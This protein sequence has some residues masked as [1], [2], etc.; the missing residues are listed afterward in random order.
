MQQAS[1][2]DVAMIGLVG[3]ACAWAVAGLF[4]WLWYNRS[5][6]M[7]LLRDVPTVP[8]KGIFVGLTETRGVVEHDEPLEAGLTGRKCVW[9]EWSVRE[10]WRRTQRYKDQKG[11]WRTRI[12]TGSDVVASGGQWTDLR[13]RDDTGAIIVRAKGADWTPTSTF[14]R[15]VG[16]R[17]PLYRTKAPGVTVNGSTGQRTF[18]ES[19]VPIGA[20][21]W[22]MG[23]AHVRADGNA[24][25]IGDGAEEGVFMIS[26]AGE[27]SHAG[28]AHFWAGFGLVAAGFAA[29]AGGAALAPVAAL[30]APGLPR[31]LP[32]LIGAVVGAVV[33]GAAAGLLWGL[34]IRN[35][36]V[37][38]RTRWERSASLVDVELK[39]RSDLIPN[40]AAVAQAGAVHERHLQ[41]CV[42]A[43]RA[44]TL[45]N[46]VCRVLAERYPALQADGAFLM[47]Q[48]QLADTEERIA[49][50]RK[51]EIESRQ[52][53]IER[54]Q[55]FPQGTVA[56]IMGVAMPPPPLPVPPAPARPPA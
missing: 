42:A 35:G 9:H 46:D 55:T 44:G 1:G 31:D 32:V 40:L 39:R 19:A 3:T 26:L 27:R 7:R 4:L 20:T 18:S 53:L 11:V 45:A 37:R 33:F 36:A 16:M 29:L 56:R 51:F 25:E 48:R 15:T 47:L 13:L 12:V 5:R 10:H 6:F 50:A 38:V 2:H 22:V 8:I 41:Q 52:A 21:A 54:L 49:L 28:W 24:L 34:L 43:L 23:N 17:D 14:Q 30:V